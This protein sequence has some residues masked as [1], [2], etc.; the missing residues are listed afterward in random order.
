MRHV[1]ISLPVTQPWLRSHERCL[2]DAYEAKLAGTTRVVAAVV[3]LP[4]ITL[5]DHVMQP[6]TGDFHLILFSIVWTTCHQGTRVTLRGTFVGWR[7]GI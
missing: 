2:Q 4:R 7:R 6:S 5:I 3:H 1:T